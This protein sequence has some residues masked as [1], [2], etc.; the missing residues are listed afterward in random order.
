MFFRGSDILDAVQ[1][2]DAAAARHFLRVKPEDVHR[3]VADGDDKGRG[4]GE[5]VGFFCYFGKPSIE[6]KC[7]SD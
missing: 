7:W 1:K 3:Q 5:V 6:K 2:G 4:L